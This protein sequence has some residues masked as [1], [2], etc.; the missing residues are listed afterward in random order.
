MR[1]LFLVG[2]NECVIGWLGIMFDSF[3]IWLAFGYECGPWVGLYGWYGDH[4]VVLRRVYWVVH[5]TL[6]DPMVWIFRIRFPQ[7]GCF[8][9]LSFLSEIWSFQESWILWVF[10]FFAKWCTKNTFFDVFWVPAKNRFLQ[11]LE[12]FVENDEK[13]SKNTKNTFRSNL[14]SWAKDA[15]KTRLGAATCKA[16]RIF[17]RV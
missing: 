16:W 3:W 12:N 4:V 17:W 14:L 13:T 1:F 6:L 11:P 2:M 9:D 10:H 15:L 8:E 5:E 7:F